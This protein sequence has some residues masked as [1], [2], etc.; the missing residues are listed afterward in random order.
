MQKYLLRKYKKKIFTFVVCRFV[1]KNAALMVR[2]IFLIF[3]LKYLV[4]KMKRKKQKTNK[5]HC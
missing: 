5:I 1:I 3:L 2:N 4:K